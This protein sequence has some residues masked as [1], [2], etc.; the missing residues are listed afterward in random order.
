MQ[1]IIPVLTYEQ[2]QAKE[3]FG[4]DYAVRFEEENKNM[5]II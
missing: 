3:G 5:I 4:D 1:Q 2:F